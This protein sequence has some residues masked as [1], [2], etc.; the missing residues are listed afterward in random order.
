MSLTMET[1]FKRTISGIALFT[2]CYHIYVALAGTPEVMTFRSIHLMLS[3]IL[4]FLVNPANKKFAASNPVISRILD[5]A[6]IAGIVASCGY[7][8]V[9]N[10]YVVNRFAY[11]DDLK[12]IEVVFGITIILLILEGTR[13]CIGLALPITASVF[14]L[15][16]LFSPQVDKNLIIDQMYLTTEGIFG[17]AIAVSATYMVLFIIFGSFVERMGTGKLFMDSA[18]SLAGSAAGGPAKVAVLTS[19]LFGTISGSPTANV[20]TTGTFTIP[21]MIKLGYRRAFA[22]AVESCASTGGQIMPPIMGA[23]AFVM[24]EFLGTSYSAVIFMAL[25]PAVLFF[26]ALFFAVHFEAKRAGIEGL[27]KEELPNLKQVLLDRGHQFIPL[28]VIVAVLMSGYSAPYAALIGAFSVIPTALLRKT[29]RNE[30]TLKSILDAL[31]AGAINNLAVAAACACAGLVIGIISLTGIGLEFS[32]F[33]VN[34]S[35]NSLILA[36]IVT[37]VAG[38][39]LGMG[40]PT[41]PSYILQAA[42]LVPAL[43]K[44]GVM[45]EAAHMFVLYFAVLSVITP[46]VAITLYAAGGISGAGIWESG[47]AAL[48]LAAAGYIIPFMFVYNPSLLMFGSWSEVAQSSI[49]AL[50][51]VVCMAGALH[52]FFLTETKGYQ[53]LILLGTAMLLIHPMVLTDLVGAALLCFIVVMQHRARNG[54]KVKG[55]DTKPT[56]IP[57]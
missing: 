51:G 40:L 41:T 11:I 56:I 8:L 33:V 24:V 43:I 53:R 22:G 16:A 31:I 30:V 28:I 34:L 32:N 45:L 26:I 14:L 29:T 39:I 21:M 44:L 13:R 5:V 1:I 42:L 47:A 36:L 9:C 4:I 15:Y 49:T 19:A 27:P 10:E 17:I 23:C 50:I 3:F 55:L 38:I 52:C 18:V 12:T 7:L 35:Q 20:M 6:M 25:I 48:K 54:S 57:E 37:A 46:P 2:A